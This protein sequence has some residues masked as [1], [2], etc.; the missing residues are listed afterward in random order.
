MKKKQPEGPPFTKHILDI[1]KANAPVAFKAPKPSSKFEKKYSL[2]IDSNLIQPSASTPVVA[3]LH[4]E[5]QQATGGPTSLGVTGEEGANPQ[6]SSGMSASIHTKPIYLTFIVIH[7]ESASEHDV[8]ASS[9]AGAYSGLFALK[10]SISQT[11]GNDEGPNKISLEHLFAR[12]NLG[13]L[14]DK[15]KSTRDGLKTAHT[16]PST[17]LDSSK[18]KKESK[19]DKDVAFGDDEFN[20]S[21]DLSSSNDTKKEIKLDSP[22]ND[23]P[24]IV[25]D[26]SD[27]EVHAERFRL[28][29]LKKL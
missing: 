8:L 20:T 19:V 21:H 26:D 28:K 1:C 7:S 5:A 22:K 13:V 29:S 27:E 6:L 25:Q 16:Y 24:I 11:I 2:A 15:I 10:D 18:T 4:K 17:N 12:I 9:K 23:E 14:V 3:E